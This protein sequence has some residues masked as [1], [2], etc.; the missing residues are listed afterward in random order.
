[1]ADYRLY[2]LDGS[3]HFIGAKE[4]TLANDAEAL[5]AA[6][7]ITEFCAGVEIWQRARMVATVPKHHPGGGSREGLPGHSR[8]A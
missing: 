3:G 8:A 2:L 7:E 4:H 6:T 5:L 1:M